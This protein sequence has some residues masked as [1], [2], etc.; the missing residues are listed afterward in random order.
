MWHDQ[1]FIFGAMIVGTIWG[2]WRSA[3][4][5]LHHLYWR[6]N[7]GIGLTRLAVIASMVW[8]L[9]VLIFFADSTIVNIWYVFYLLMSYTAIKLF[10]QKGAE[11]FGVRLRVDVYERKN[12]AAA[13]IIA[14]FTLATGLIFGGSMWGES[15]P[16]SLEYGGI[17]EMLPGYEDGWWITPWFFLMGWG[18]L[19]GTMLLW[20]AS[21]AGQRIRRDRN[22]E[23]ARAAAIY[24]L[25]CAI[26][27]TDAVAGNYYGL[28]D[29]FLGFAVI[30]FP[31]LAHE[32]IKPRPGAEERRAE[33]PWIYIIV[34]IAVVV[35]TPFVSQWLGFR[36]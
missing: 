26:P 2:L 8:C 35:I 13:T 20:F 22:M 5:H 16:E 36:T 3:N 1:G 9:F 6:E 15:T 17:F 31:V 21:E 4:S 29:S 19:L 25:C 14:A 7:Y 33:E 10:G 11:L 12:F 32:W 34:A 18:I 28:A 23:E 24:C 27:L 30:A